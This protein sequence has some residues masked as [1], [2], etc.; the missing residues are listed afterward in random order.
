MEMTLKLITISMHGYSFI[1]VTMIVS[2]ATSMH[3]LMG[4]LLFIIAVDY[5]YKMGC[6]WQL[7][8]AI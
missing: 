7:K 3:A 5:H 2:I 4:I 8:Y 6:V 1:D